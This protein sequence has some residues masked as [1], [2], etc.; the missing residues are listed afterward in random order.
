MTA[1]TAVAVFLVGF[2]VTFASQ[3]LVLV[4]RVAL[5]SWRLDW[6]PACYRHHVVPR[7]PRP[8]LPRARALRRRRC[9]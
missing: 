7:A 2:A 6:C 9:P 3:L 4:I 8:A 1:A 5:C